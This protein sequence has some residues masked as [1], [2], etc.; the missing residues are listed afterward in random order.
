MSNI[1]MDVEVERKTLMTKMP[2]GVNA[3]RIGSK[4]M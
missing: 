2:P 1:K 4:K 3:T